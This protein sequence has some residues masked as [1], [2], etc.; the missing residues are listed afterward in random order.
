M[1]TITTRNGVEYS[2]I[3]VVIPLA[4]KTKAREKGISLSKTLTE[5]LEK[6]MK[7]KGTARGQNATNTETPAPLSIT[8]DEVD[9]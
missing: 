8:R 2:P 7:K 5:A 4:I 9:V 1:S 6:K 3:T